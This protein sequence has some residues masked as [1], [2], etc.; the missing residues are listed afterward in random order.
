[1]EMHTSA[2]VVEHPKAPRSGRA[3]RKSIAS[4]SGFAP[5]A[6]C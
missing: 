3:K 1:M 4:A 2:A 6:A 5:R